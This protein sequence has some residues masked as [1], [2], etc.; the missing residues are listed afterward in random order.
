MEI[1]VS[2]KNLFVGRI[3]LTVLFKSELG[4]Y[5]GGNIS[6]LL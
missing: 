5:D 3:S 4:E 6:E 2:D 1:Y